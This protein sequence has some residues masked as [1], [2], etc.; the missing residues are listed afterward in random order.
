MLQALR[1]DLGGVPLVRG[2]LRNHRAIPPGHE[3]IDQG[4]PPP[5][6]FGC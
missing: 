6:I 2:V 5:L 3:G 1:G 4:H